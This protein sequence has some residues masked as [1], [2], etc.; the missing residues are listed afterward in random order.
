MRFNRVTMLKDSSINHNIDKL[1]PR[2]K[3]ILN[4]LFVHNMSKTTC[5]WLFRMNHKTFHTH[6]HRIIKSII[7]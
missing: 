2:D 4:M 3:Q 6:L 5:K 1:C 7:E